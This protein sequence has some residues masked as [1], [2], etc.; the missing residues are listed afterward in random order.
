[1]LCSALA[2]N[3]IKIFVD[4]RNINDLFLVERNQQI[5]ETYYLFYFILYYLFELLFVVGLFVF[6]LM[7]GCAPKL[8]L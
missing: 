1:M 4:R 2:R 5:I 3:I 8:Y 6:G 7:M